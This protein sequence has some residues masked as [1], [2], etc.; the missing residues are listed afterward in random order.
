M[1]LLSPFI[2]VIKIQDI[3]SQ[4]LS[5]GIR[6]YGHKD[7]SYAPDFT[8]ALSMI[9]HKIKKNDIVLTLGAGD[10]YTLGEE[11]AKIL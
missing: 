9:T 6:K 10:I 11:L 8:Q 5:E 1:N 7:V 3:D 2:R 4:R